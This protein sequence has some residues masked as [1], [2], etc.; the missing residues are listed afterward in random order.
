LKKDDNFVTIRLDETLTKKQEIEGR[1]KCFRIR[2]V[3]CYCIRDRTCVFIFWVRVWN[4]FEYRKEKLLLLI[5]TRTFCHWSFWLP[6]ELFKI[7]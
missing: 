1:Q 4:N 5:I 2:E 6:P 7:Y 3:Y